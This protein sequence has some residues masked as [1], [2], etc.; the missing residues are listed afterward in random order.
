MPVRVV[1]DTGSV[2]ADSRVTFVSPQVDDQTQ[3][4]LAKAAVDGGGKLRP[5]QLVRV[6]LVWGTR[7]G[8][9]VPALAPPQVTVLSNYIGASAQVVETAVTIPLEQQINGA[10]GLKYLT[11]SS[12]NDGTSSIVATFDLTRDPDLAA[13]DIQNRVNIA[14]GRL[15]NEVKQ[16]GISVVKSA[17]NFVFGAAIYAEDGRYGTAFMSNY[18]DVYVRDALK[19]V[20]GVADV[21]IFGERRYAMRLWLDPVRVASRGLSA[22]DVVAALREQNV[23]VAAGQ[24]GQQPAPTGQSLQVSVRAVGRLSEPAEFENIIVKAAGDTTV[25]LK[26]VG[27]VELGAEDY[28][29]SLQF[30]GHDAIGIAITQLSNANA[31]EVDR[32]ALAELERLSQN[33]PPGMKYRVA[34]DTTDVVS[35]SI[36]D[37]IFTLAGAIA[38]VIL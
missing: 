19:R 29:S 38:L 21:F 22:S 1:D 30:N 16:T 27:R 33:F 20:T 13:V 3:T 23:Q 18:L 35:A 9:V 6:R 2:L 17:S 7:E 24:V 26:D 8:P 28:A 4:V 32:A 36:H 14:M 31:L 34:F 5:A 25:R 12:G 37:V 10:Q 15:P 11:S